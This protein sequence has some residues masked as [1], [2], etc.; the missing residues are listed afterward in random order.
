MS[1]W[2]DNQTAVPVTTVLAT[3]VR[4]GTRML[5]AYAQTCVIHGSQLP[6]W[7]SG[8][9]HWRFNRDA[10][11]F[12][13][14]KMSRNGNV[15][16]MNMHGRTNTPSSGMRP[17]WLKWPDTPVNCCSRKPS[18][19]TWPCWGTHQWPLLRNASTE[20]QDLSSLDAGWLPWED[21]KA[22]PTGHPLIDLPQTPVT[23]NDAVYGHKN[24][25]ILF[26]DIFALKKTGASWLKHWHVFPHFQAG[27]REP[28]ITHAL[29][30]REAPLHMLRQFEMQN[31]VGVSVP[32][33]RDQL[34]S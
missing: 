30:S 32:E 1:S 27:N 33:R 23:V 2:Q 13:S 18:T 28:C 3:R 24:D 29:T 5:W 20:T 11:V 8:K 19:S 7:K 34:Y 22:G 6:A 17:Q 16:F 25:T 31:C 4:I 14:A 9:T 15:S 26:C 21:R 10:P 12:F